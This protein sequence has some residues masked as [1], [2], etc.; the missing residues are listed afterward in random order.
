MSQFGQCHEKIQSRGT[1][2]AIVVDIF[3]VVKTSLLC[4]GTEN[5]LKRTNLVN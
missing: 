1:S 3:V 2:V 5:E 4:V